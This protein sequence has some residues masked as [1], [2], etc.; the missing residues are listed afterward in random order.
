VVTTTA[1]VHD[2]TQFEK[3]TEDESKAV[4]ADSGYMSKERKRSLRESGIFCGIVERRVRGQKELRAKQSKNN[5]RFASIRAAV[6]MPFAFIKRLMNYTETKY[7]GLHKNS[8]YHYLLAAAYN[9]RRIPNLV[10]RIDI[11]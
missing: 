7:L 10:Q 9:L 8:Q 3:L 5:S 6:E 1:R 4:F 11:R 2:S